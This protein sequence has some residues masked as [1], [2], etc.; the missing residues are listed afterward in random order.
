MRRTGSLKEVMGRSLGGEQA[1]EE[2]PSWMSH[3]SGHQ[4]SEPTQWHVTHPG[5]A[6]DLSQWKLTQLETKC[7]YCS[8][9]A[10]NNDKL[11]NTVS[12]FFFQLLY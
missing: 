11:N 6:R 9:W 1:A 7:I 12:F 2:G 10:L 5:S 4:E 3:L 8:C